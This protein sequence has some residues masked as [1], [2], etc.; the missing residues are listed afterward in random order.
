MIASL[1]GQIVEQGVARGR[2]HAEEFGF[3]N[4]DRPRTARPAPPIVPARQT[5]RR[6][7]AG[8]GAIA[9]A[10]PALAIAVVVGSYAAAQ[11]L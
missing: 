6:M 11:A 5:D 9:F 8:I 2:I 4:V 10:G 3:A 1:R 7:L